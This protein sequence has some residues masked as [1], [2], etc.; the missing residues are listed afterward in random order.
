M[1]DINNGQFVPWMRHA[2][3][4]MNRHRQKTFVLALS[5]KTI[6]NEARL[7]ESLGDIAMLKSLGIKI[8][9]VFGVRPQ[10]N[11]NLQE[12]EISST[13]TLSNL[14]VTTAAMMSRLWQVAGE[15]TIKI[16]AALSAGLPD[17][18]LHEARINV[19]QANAV[20]AKPLGIVDGVDYQHTGKVRKVNAA[21]IRQLLET[22]SIVLIPPLGYSLTG[23]TFNLEYLDLAEKVATSLQADKLIVFS[24]HHGIL[25]NT[26]KCIREIRA[27]EAENIKAISNNQR[28]ILRAA[29]AACQHGVKRTH[30]VNYN[31]DGSLLK[32]LF[33]R[34]GCGTMISDDGYDQLRD[35]RIEDI[36]GIMNLIQPLEANGTLVRRSRE[37]LESEVT[38]FMVITRDN[39]VIGCAALYYF[40]KG[41]SAELACIVSHSSYKGQGLGERLLN[42]AQTRASEMG[43]KRLF[44]LTTQTAHWFMQHGF[45]ASSVDTLPEDKRELYNFQRASKV[46]EKPLV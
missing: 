2:A 14:R 20:T 19:A 11:A 23:E 34:D 10:L 40:D 4:Y 37:R 8:V 36:S 45:K 26:G 17:S 27:N 22:D 46:F 9:I 33:T 39:H 44:V 35:A 16:Q 1:S 3:P 21:Q 6:A 13:Y 32:E 41:R 25:N 7:L 18:P 15:A 43:A 24:K 29:A 30:V 31:E 38:Q 12:K 5:G 28:K 42:A